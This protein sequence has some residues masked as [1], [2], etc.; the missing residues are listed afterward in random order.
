MSRKALWTSLGASLVL[1]GLVSFGPGVEKARADEGCYTVGD[2][3][4]VC[5][6]VQVC[7]LGGCFYWTYR[8]GPACRPAG[9][10]PSCADEE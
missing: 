3:G 9:A 6:L 7:D 10:G 8:E 5:A 4:T 1:F 2:E